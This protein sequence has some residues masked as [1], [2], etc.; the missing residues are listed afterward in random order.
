F[1]GFTTPSDFLK[2]NKALRARTNVYSKNY[3]AALNDL[4]ASFLNTTAPIGLATGVYW[5][6]STNPGDLVNPNYDPT[7][8]Q[9]FAH[10]SFLANAQ[11]KPDLTKDN[12]ALTKV[13]P[14]DTV[15]R[16]TP[17]FVLTEKLMVYT[18]NGAP[19]PIIRNEELILLRAEANIALNNNTAA[20]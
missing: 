13:A 4:A 19:I 15:K 16:G 12:R 20:I 14:I 5:D 7:T 8:R 6:F 11:L 1:T 10:P 17:S 2:F 18:S 9:R 3:S